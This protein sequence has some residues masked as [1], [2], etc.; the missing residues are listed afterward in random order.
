M[1]NMA[2]SE[3]GYTLTEVIVAVGIMVAIMSTVGT[4]TFQAVATQ[5]KIVSDGLAIN[6]LRKSLSWF[7]TD[8]KMAQTTDLT[9]GGSAATITISWTDQY[10]GNGVLHTATYTQVEDRLVRTYDGVSHTVGRGVSSVLF[11]RSGN[12]IVTQIEVQVSPGVTRTLG[13]RAVTRSVLS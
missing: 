4:A 12:T 2:S 3:K 10:Q 6:E 5:D 8:M 13:V 9:D 11:T 7:S 1:R